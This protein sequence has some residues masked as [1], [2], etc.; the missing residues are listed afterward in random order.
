MAGIGARRRRDAGQHVGFHPKQ[1]LGIMSVKALA[2]KI[3][4]IVLYE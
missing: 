1:P 3:A 4:K 2:S